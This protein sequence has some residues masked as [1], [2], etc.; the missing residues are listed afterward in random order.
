MADLYYTSDIHGYLF[1]T[2]YIST[3]GDGMGY[4]QAASHFRKG[5]LILD[6]GDIL[7]GS[8]LARYVLK[9]GIRPFPQA[10][11][12]RQA[13]VCAYIPGNHDFNYGPDTLFNFIQDATLPLL[14]ANLADQSGRMPIIPYKV[15]TTDDGLRIGIVGVITDYVNIWERAEN[16]G[17][18][19]VT[20]SVNAAGKALCALRQESPDY[21]VCVY[22]G[23]YDSTETP[24]KMQE[25][26]A[27][28]LCALGF[29][30]LL[31]A[32]QHIVV[33]PKVIGGTLT[34][35]TG[36]MGR[37]Y[38][39]LSFSTERH[40]VT[41]EVLPSG[42]GTPVRDMT[43]VKRQLQHVQEQVLDG[44]KTI[45]GHTAGPF[46][47]KGKLDSALCGSSLADFFNDVQLQMT[48]AD[49]SCTSLFNE[50]RNLG[51]VVTMGELI[52]CYPFPNTLTI[53]EV[54][55]TVL[56]T[57]L[58]RVAQY[59]D[60][61]D[62]NGIVISQRFLVP[63]VEHY[64]FDF[65]QNI[66]YAIDAA[67]PLGE[68]VVE[69]SW[70]GTDLLTHPSTTLTLVMNN[71]RASGTGGYEVFTTCPIVKQYGDDMQEILVHWFATNP[72]LPMPP[73]HDWR[74]FASQNPVVHPS[75]SFS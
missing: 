59:Y 62:T 64:N 44:L 65:Y 11:A 39:H 5:S 1:D 50:P 67:K 6:G 24:G 30:V 38:A 69:L 2:D 7:Q 48:G 26:R 37:W 66:H 27:E 8:A 68:R 4:F 43:G 40:S 46:S 36:T 3:E 31:T 51:P 21:T 56:K 70:K 63:K 20:D 29:D 42:E 23:G 9:N 74:V 15:F 73:A 14:A 57:A 58:E 60:F 71:Y 55:G 13:G 17:S 41:A 45:I 22:H 52:A 72:L 61:D 35:Q 18:L 53:L 32:H 10:E 19:R 33:Q 12:L 47:D 49:I 16:L 28:E 54:N 34:L 75:V 25:N